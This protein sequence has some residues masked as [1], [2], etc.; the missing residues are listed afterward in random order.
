MEEAELNVHPKGLI[1]LEI[2]VN[3]SFCNNI[4][5]ITHKSVKLDT[6]K[7]VLWKSSFPSQNK[8]KISL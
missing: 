4:K 8:V 6:H 7:K 3:I 2:H 1:L 5:N